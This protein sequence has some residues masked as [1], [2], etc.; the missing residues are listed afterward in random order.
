MREASR[1]EAAMRSAHKCRCK[2]QESEPPGMR[3]RWGHT[4]HLTN[5]YAP[6]GTTDRLKERRVMTSSFSQQYFTG[7]VVATSTFDE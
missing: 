4:L 2:Q 7:P 3:K 1:W 5:S 6:R